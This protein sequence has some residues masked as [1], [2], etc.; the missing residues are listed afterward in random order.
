[1]NH[2]VLNLGYR[3]AKLGWCVR[4]DDWNGIRKALRIN[5][6]LWGGRFNPIIIVEDE[7]SAGAVLKK[8]RPDFLFA[9]E[10]DAVVRK[11]IK[12]Q[13][14]LPS[15][16]EMEES[17][18]WYKDLLTEQAYFSSIVPFLDRH[19]F[20]A[21]DRIPIRFI[22]DAEDELKDVFRATFGELPNSI[23][24]TI[25]YAAWFQGNGRAY[26]ID[27]PLDGAL[28][29]DCF[30]NNLLTLNRI[31]HLELEL[32]M[33][34]VN[35]PLKAPGL[36]IGEPQNF[37]DIS[38]Y[39]NIRALG[40]E[41]FFVP[42]NREKR[43]LPAIKEYFKT[44]T[45]PNSPT[46]WTREMVG[47]DILKNLLRDLLPDDFNERCKI[48]TVS[49]SL[50]KDPYI[51]PL[52]LS[53]KKTSILT[54]VT[55]TD[56]GASI[57]FVLPPKPTEE[58]AILQQVMLNIQVM[59]GQLALQQET[60]RIPE[61]PEL[62]EF[63]GMKLTSRI[64]WWHFRVQQNY[65][66]VLI[67]NFEQTLTIKSLKGREFFNEFFKRKGMDYE[68]SHAGLLTTRMLDQLG[69]EARMR[70]FK[71]PSVRHLLEENP[72]ATSFSYKKACQTLGGKQIG[73]PIGEQNILLPGNKPL[74]P[75]MVLRTL[76]D[77][78]VLRIGMELICPYCELK[79]WVSID[80]LRSRSECNLCGKSFDIASQID[81]QDWY[82]T[83][84][85]IFSYRADQ[86]GAIPVALTMNRIMQS[87]SETAR[88]QSYMNSW[89]AN[90][91]KTS[92][93]KKLEN[94][95]SCEVDLLHLVVHEN[96]HTDLLLGECKGRGRIEPEDVHNLKVLADE[97][98]SENLSVFILFSKLSEFSKEE[99]ETISTAGIPD[100]HRLILL[101][102]ADLDRPSMMFE[103]KQPQWQPVE[104]NLREM[105]RTTYQAYFRDGSED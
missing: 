46:V 35:N 23:D 5:H 42:V 30:S 65:I 92:S 73:K 101:E 2:V 41:I 38:S 102:G 55:Q 9:V 3:P 44:F 81:N 12:T 39:W 70:I 94:A 77:W 56:R 93:Q 71:I 96:G 15:I 14:H 45:K 61:I 85:G 31:T 82:Y 80:H 64:K 86:G 62:N 74:T 24:T 47:D 89:S 26:T 50:F 40:A 27:L 21:G 87:L 13:V 34:Y 28:P 6:S 78:S 20:R 97:I 104:R 54:P 83:T 19:V 29:S 11:F 60:F 76:L 43:V 100:Y 58:T 95:S 67:S 7:T 105:A 33:P 75:P 49:S 17:K 66:S 1:M 52:G 72:P 37:V 32:E 91:Q 16:G 99:L 25:D 69:G 8:H 63:Y 103:A 59:Q 53:T 90:I 68:L 10:E 51:I 84:S 18:L 57:E 98:R 88:F 79:F 48:W 36:Y 22:W 4:M